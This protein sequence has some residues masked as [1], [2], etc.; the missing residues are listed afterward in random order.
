MN[1]DVEWIPLLEFIHNYI[2]LAFLGRLCACTSAYLNKMDAT[3]H[4]FPLSIKLIN[5]NVKKDHLSIETT[6]GWYANHLSR[7]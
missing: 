5:K 7:T 3:H 2:S 1:L 4:C 6:A